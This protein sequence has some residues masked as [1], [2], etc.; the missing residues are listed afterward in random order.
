MCLKLIL[1]IS[2]VL[3]EGQLVSL[4]SQASK[5]VVGLASGT[6]VICEFGD[7]RPFRRSEVRG[8]P[9]HL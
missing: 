1:V 5:R 9:G 8:G 7:S 4:E 3:V 6:S 2:F